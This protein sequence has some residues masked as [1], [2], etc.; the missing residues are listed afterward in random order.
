MNCKSSNNLISGYLTSSEIKLARNF[1]VKIVQKQE[2]SNEYQQLK[3]NKAV[4]SSSKIL[5]LNLFLDEESLIRAGGRLEN[6]QLSNERKHPILLPKNHH[7]TNLIIIHYHDS[8]LHAGTLL[9]LS[10]IRKEFWIVT[11][12][13]FIKR[14]I[15][16]CIKCFRLKEKTASQKMAQLPPSRVTPSRVFSK[17]GL[18]YAGPF[19]VNPRSG[20]GVIS[21]K[22]YVCIF[23]CF[24]TKVVYIEVVENLS[25]ESFIV[26]LKRFVA[27]RGKPNE[28][29]SDCGSNFFAANKEINRVVKSFRKEES[30]H[31]YFAEEQIKWHFNPPSAPH[32]G[33]IWEAAVKSAKSHLKRTIGDHKLTLEEFL[34]PIAQIESCLNSRPLCPVSDD[35]A[36]QSALT[37]GHFLVGASLSSIPEETYLL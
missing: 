4:S 6:T 15:W 3:N 5:S 13:S 22:M 36:E 31:Q 11:A 10:V 8:F 29:F 17:T 19:F 26:A 23:V 25:A 32:F 35:P 28:F 12:R 27:R 9:L 1:L 7:L 24:A 30:I 2:F 34:T 20:R 33:E 18:D 14:Q 21:V 37:P 16:K